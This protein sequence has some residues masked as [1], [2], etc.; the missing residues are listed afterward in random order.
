MY[1]S[2]QDVVLEQL[3]F[4]FKLV[5]M[6]KPG[7]ICRK[8]KIHIG[9]VSKVALCPRGSCLILFQSFS[10]RSRCY[11]CFKNYRE[12]VR[13]FL[14]AQTTLSVITWMSVDLSSVRS[15]LSSRTTHTCV[16]V[17]CLFL[18]LGIWVSHYPGGSPWSFVSLEVGVKSDSSSWALITIWSRICY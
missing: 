18:S 17:S 9:C 5:C 12:P 8:I 13:F 1:G 16:S 4:E 6:E 3:L 15:P 7:L 11:L 10:W 14:M 2:T